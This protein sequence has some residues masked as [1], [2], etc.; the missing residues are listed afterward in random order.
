[1]TFW[2][3]F[4]MGLTFSSN[5]LN[6]IFTWDWSWPPMFLCSHDLCLFLF[7]CF[8]LHMI[9][10]PR[11]V[12]ILLWSFQLQS[13]N[14]WTHPHPH[15][16]LPFLQHPHPYTHHP[17]PRNTGQSGGERV[18]APTYDEEEDPGSIVEDCVWPTLGIAMVK[19]VLPSNPSVRL[20]APYYQEP[21]P[22][23]ARFGRQ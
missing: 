5:F 10:W 20:A 11:E 21:L 14:L 3:I 13:T 12:I 16:L 15:F 1:M 8:I 9:I 19:W 18:M 2:Y 4:G 6:F 23:Q 7:L 22:D 17:G